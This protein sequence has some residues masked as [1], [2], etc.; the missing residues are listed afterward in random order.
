MQG[1]INISSLIRLLGVGVLVLGLAASALAAPPA[2]NPG[3]PFAEILAQIRI[4]NGKLDA[5]QGD[6]NNL[7][8]ALGP[9]EVPPVWGQTYATADRFV[10]V[11]GGAAF[12]DKATGLVWDG[13]PNPTAQ[14]SW[15]SAISHCTTR[16]V[17]GQW[18]FHLP[19]IEQLTSL[20]PL[21]ATDLNSA[22]GDGPF[23]IEQSARYWS[24]T[25]DVGNPANAWFV[26]FGSGA[27]VANDK[28]SFNHAWCVR[29][30]Q[31]FDGNTHNTLH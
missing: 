1:L 15:Q 4:L 22:T 30:G 23:S 24:A 13:S 17:G 10:S 26:Y 27:V 3:Q 9:C 11:L 7:P 12:C 19:L 20:L 18:G 8:G 5:L 2:S 6:V 31:S 29:G 21:L 16:T 14:P 28:V 25:T